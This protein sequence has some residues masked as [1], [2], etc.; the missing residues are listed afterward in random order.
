M[1]VGEEGGREGGRLYTYH[2][3]VTNRMIL[4][5]EIGTRIES[6]FNVPIGSDGPKSQDG[7]HKPQPF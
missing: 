5:L 1:E 7:V 2:Y 6:H 4:A 3:T